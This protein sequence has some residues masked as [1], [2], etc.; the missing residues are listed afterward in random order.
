MEA[1]QQRVIDE[2]KVVDFRR[3]ALKEFTE[4]DVFSA[5]PDKERTLL[6]AQFLAMTTYYDILLQRIELFEED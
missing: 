3:G 1:Y 5:L 4:T 2:A 6:N